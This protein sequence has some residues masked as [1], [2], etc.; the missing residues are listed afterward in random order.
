MSEKIIIKV[1]LA[2]EGQKA[3]A[4]MEY[5]TY[6]DLKKFHNT[7]PLDDMIEVLRTEIERGI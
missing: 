2:V 1:E 3:S 4:N 6:Q 5:D 7:D